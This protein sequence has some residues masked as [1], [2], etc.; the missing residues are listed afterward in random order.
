MELILRH[1][2]SIRYLKINPGNENSHYV[3]KLNN[4]SWTSLW[5]LVI[6]QTVRCAGGHG[7]L[8]IDTTTVRRTSGRGL[9]TFKL[10]SALSYTH[11][12]SAPL[13]RYSQI[14]SQVDKSSFLAPEWQI[15]YPSTAAKLNTLRNLTL[16]DALKQRTWQR[17]GHC[18][19]HGDAGHRCVKHSDGYRKAHQVLNNCLV[20]RTLTEMFLDTAN[21]P[22]HC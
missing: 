8:H 14:R 1:E 11:T 17:Q 5:Q 22:E 20:I 4:D 13:D 21:K 9:G 19:T 10:N 15:P 7:R 3:A 6:V 16:T 18:N 12:H 2:G